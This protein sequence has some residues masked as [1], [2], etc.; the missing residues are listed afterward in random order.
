VSDGCQF[1]V[2]IRPGAS[3]GAACGRP[4]M[5]DDAHTN[6]PPLPPYQPILNARTV[7]A[8]SVEDTYS[9]KDAPERALTRSV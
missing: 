3:V 6:R 5:V 9:R 8:P 2:I 4:G 7:N 1:V